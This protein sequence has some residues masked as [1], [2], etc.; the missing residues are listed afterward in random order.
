MGK[1]L[2]ELDKLLKDNFDDYCKL[3]D[4]PNFVCKKCGRAANEKK[5]LC[6]GQKIKR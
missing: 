3:V 1:T 2:C 6:K 5:V 4:K